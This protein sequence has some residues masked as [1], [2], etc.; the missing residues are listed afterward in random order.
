MDWHEFHSGASFTPGTVSPKVL[1]KRLKFMKAKHH[2][3]TKC[4][5]ATLV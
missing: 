2:Y 3:D 1:V 4:V 5:G